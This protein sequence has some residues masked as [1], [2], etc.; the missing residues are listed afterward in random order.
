MLF[1]DTDVLVQAIDRDGALLQRLDDLSLQD[2][3]A[4]TSINVAEVLRGAMRSPRELAVATAVLESFT[5][6]PFGPRAARRFGAL[7]SM[8]DRAG[9]PMPVQDGLIA[10]VVLEDGGRLLSGNARHFERVPGLELLPLR[11]P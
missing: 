5:H 7:M 4:V 6:V 1:L 9:R 11:G 2:E 10:A 8:L 3:L